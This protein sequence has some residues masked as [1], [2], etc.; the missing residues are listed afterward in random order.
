MGRREGATVSRLTV[1]T[2][3][4]VF[5]PLCLSHQLARCLPVLVLHLL[6]VLFITYFSPKSKLPEGFD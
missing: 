2:V 3:K 6:A 5:L 1:L 4:M